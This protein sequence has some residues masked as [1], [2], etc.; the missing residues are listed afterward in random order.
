M[1]D[2]I[3]TGSNKD[4]DLIQWEIQFK[5]EHPIALN[6]KIGRIVGFIA[7]LFILAIPVSLVIVGV[8]W[9]FTRWW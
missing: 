1:A 8:H 6:V 5:K 7:I 9:I 3:P 2:D 4:P